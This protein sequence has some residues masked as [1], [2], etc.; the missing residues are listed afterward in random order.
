MG[1]IKFEKEG[2]APCKALTEWLKEN[3]I[4]YA[5]YNIMDNL[6]MVK[7]YN[8]KSV[9]VLIS[10]DGEFENGRVIGFSESKIEEI[11]TLVGL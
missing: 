8:L 9:P 5:S 1:L 2:C 6:R 3:N 10:L 7:Q 4:E 11:K